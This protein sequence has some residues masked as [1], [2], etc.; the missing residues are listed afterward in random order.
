VR[1]HPYWRGRK[2]IVWNQ[3]NLETYDAVI[4]S[5]W[6]SAFNR[7]ELLQWADCIIDTRNALAGAKAKKGQVVKA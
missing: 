3:K 1:K 6:H 2:S 7:K 5:T 4:I